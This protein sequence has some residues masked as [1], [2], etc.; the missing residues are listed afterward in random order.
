MLVRAVTIEDL[1]IVREALAALIEQA[2][3]GAA[4]PR[5]AVLKQR[6]GTIEAMYEDPELLE[7]VAALR[8]L[9]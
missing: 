5:P 1:E 6:L 8:K 2:E 9:L 7:R 4:I 3:D